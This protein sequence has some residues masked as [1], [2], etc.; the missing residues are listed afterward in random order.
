MLTESP[1]NDIG[2]WNFECSGGQPNGT[3]SVVPGLHIKLLTA[4]VP[5]DCYAISTYDV[6]L[7][8]NGDGEN[9]HKNIIVE[10]NSGVDFTSNLTGKPS[11]CGIV[12]NDIKFEI[13]TACI[14]L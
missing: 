10:S 3:V 7:W 11:D 2:L 12:V 5:Q 14:C 4:N 1:L 13:K 6:V 9:C 8:L